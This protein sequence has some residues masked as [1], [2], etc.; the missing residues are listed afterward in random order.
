MSSDFLRDLE[1]P[2]DLLRAEWERDLIDEFSSSGELF[3]VLF[4]DD[5]FLVV[6]MSSVLPGGPFT[7]A[8]A[9]DLGLFDVVEIE[10]SSAS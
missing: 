10:A 5:S 8:F 3:V 7:L 6:S 2:A 1:L 9:F 4:L